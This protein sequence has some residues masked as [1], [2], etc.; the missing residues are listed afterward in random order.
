VNVLCALETSTG[1]PTGS[2]LSTKVDDSPILVENGVDSCRKRA[3]LPSSALL[4]RPV[5]G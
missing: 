4:L 2:H 5:N 1:M 3:Y